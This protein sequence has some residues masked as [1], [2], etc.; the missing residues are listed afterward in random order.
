[1]GAPTTYVYVDLEGTAQLAGRLWVT[2]SKGR[3]TATFEYDRRWLELDQRFALEPALAL[4]P[5]PFHTQRGR[6]LFGALG[7]AAP[8]HG[9]MLIGRAE[10]RLAAADERRPRSLR[11]IDYLLGVTDELRQ[12]AVR[13]AA[14]EG[15]AFLAEGGRETVPPL[16]ELSRLL[17]A[18]DHVLAD[19]ETDEDLRLLL[20]PGSSLGGARPK[21]SVR[22][23]DGTLLIAK[24][25]SPADGYDVVRWEAVALALASKAGI[26]VPEWKLETVSG[27]DVLLTRRFDRRGTVRIP[28]LSALSALGAI[29]GETRSYLEIA[30]ALRQHGAAVRQDLP[31]LW[32]RI[33][34]NVLISNTDDHLRNHAFLYG[35]PDGWRLSPAYDINPVPTDVRPR[36]LSTAIG[37]E[38]DFTASLALAMDVAGDFGLSAPRARAITAAVGGAVAGWRTE[39][40]RL[41]ISTAETER[42]SSAFEHHDLAAALAGGPSAPG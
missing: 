18:S 36:V 22:D 2:A 31:E 30:D 39:A 29:D 21:A 17:A 28:F 20:A 13:F 24:F 11:E 16:V 4:G 6:A 25:P 15:G 32:R 8:D 26:T 37:A 19:Q 35:G 34:F 40:A 5:G 27:R 41:R 1:M 33:V 42:M 38:E 12:G 14:S 7:D 9:R 3:E 10:R 23:R